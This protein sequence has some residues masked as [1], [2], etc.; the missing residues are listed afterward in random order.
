VVYATG[1]AQLV[2]PKEVL[3]ESIPHGIKARAHMALN[4][5]LRHDPALRH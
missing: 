3:G 5:D 1:A 2:P 4:A